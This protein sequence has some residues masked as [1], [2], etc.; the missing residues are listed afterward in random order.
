MRELFTNWKMSLF[1]FSTLS[2]WLVSEWKK[3]RLAIA[4]FDFTRVGLIFSYL[5]RVWAR[6]KIFFG[7]HRVQIITK[8]YTFI[9]G[10]NLDLVIGFIKSYFLSSGCSDPK[11]ITYL[12]FGFLKNTDIAGQILGQFWTRPSP[13]FYICTE[14]WSK[15][16]YISNAFCGKWELRIYG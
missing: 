2:V 3:I 14:R 10:L 12:R 7:S 15:V 4:Y 8:N 9:L 13:R 1:L 6:W 5:V 16:Q 11:N